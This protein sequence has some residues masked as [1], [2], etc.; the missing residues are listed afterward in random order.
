MCFFNI[1]DIILS[2]KYIVEDNE[3]DPWEVYEGE[4]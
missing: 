3:Y 4:I 2:M 1:Y